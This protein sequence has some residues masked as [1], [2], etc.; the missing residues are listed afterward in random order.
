RA[1]VVLLRRR[2]VV[3]PEHRLTGDALRATRPAGG[4]V[5]RGR[6]TDHDRQQE[7]QEHLDHEALIIADGCLPERL[8]RARVVT[9]EKA[10]GA[11]VEADILRAEALRVVRDR[12]EVER[13]AE[14]DGVRRV[15]VRVE[16]R[17]TE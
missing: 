10:A 6:R 3:E 9:V 2:L 8:A 4:R 1:V 15:S 16:G 5:Q 14:L 7:V 17:E 13:S 12:G 11:R